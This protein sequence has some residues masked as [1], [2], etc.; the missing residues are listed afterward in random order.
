MKITTNQIQQLINPGAKY[1]RIATTLLECLTI[2][3]QLAN[4]EMQSW[5]FNRGIEGRQARLKDLEKSFEAM[6]NTYNSIDKDQLIAQIA[7]F[8]E[9][10]AFFYR[11]NYLSWLDSMGLSSLESNLN[12]AEEMLA[13]K[14]RLPELRPFRDY[15]DHTDELVIILEIH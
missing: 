5:Y 10:I 6:R 2:D 4:P 1:G 8:K 11:R 13:L 15:H 3:Q 9:K 12:F 7:H 14:A